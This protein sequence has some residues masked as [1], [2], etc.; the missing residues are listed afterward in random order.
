MKHIKLLLLLFVIS[1]QAQQGGMW[2]P[3]L[4]NGMNETEMKSLG[5][6]IS[7]KDIYELLYRKNITLEEKDFAIGVRIEHPQQLINEIQYGKEYARAIELNQQGALPPASYSLVEQVDGRGVFSFCMCPGGIIAPASTENKSLVVNGWSP[8]KRNNPFANSGL[9][10]KVGQEDFGGFKNESVLAGLHFQ[11]SIEQKAFEIGGGKFVAPAQKLA[12]FLKNK[13]S[14]T[15]GD[16]S[17]LPGV[18]PANMKDVLPPF[19][20]N[21]IQQGVKQFSK[22][23]KNYIHPDA[24]LVATESRT[25]SPVRIPRDK[26]TLQHIHIKGLF[27]CAEGAGYAGGIISAAIDGERVADASFL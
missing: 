24:I 5:M 18:L 21:S 22:R 25:S 16:N 23:V 4:L 9:V 27:P 14:Q 2:I 13:P 1:T 11:Q 6:K 12:D 10:V 3:S 20:Y 26:E 7:A 19:I 8:S 17:Y 15:I